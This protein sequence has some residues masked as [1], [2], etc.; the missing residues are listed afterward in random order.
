MIINPTGN[1]RSEKA[2]YTAESAVATPG[3]SSTVLK[4]VASDGLLTKVT[5]EGD[6]N[7]VASNIKKGVTIFGVTG[8]YSATTTTSYYM[9][10]VSFAGSTSQPNFSMTAGYETIYYANATSTDLRKPVLSAND[11]FSSWSVTTDSSGEVV[12]WK[13]VSE[14]KC[15]IKDKS[16]KEDSGYDYDTSYAGGQCVMPYSVTV[17]TSNF[18]S[19]TPVNWPK[20]TYKVTITNFHFPSGFKMCYFP[21]T[22]SSFTN[23]SFEATL[24]VSSS[25]AVLTWTVPSTWSGW[26]TF[27]LG[28]KGVDEYVS[29]YGESYCN[30]FAQVTKILS[31][32]PA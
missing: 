4:P 1:A 30:L 13:N 8:T 24:K 10:I 25:G 18:W 7:L 20:G 9:P 29:V 27:I 26:R 22:S 23:S 16:W 2:A 11:G 31:F 19:Y 3:A 12:S 14:S 28:W 17:T 21:N 15:T 6:A 5:V 32:T